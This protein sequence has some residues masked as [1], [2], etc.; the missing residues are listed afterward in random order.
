[1]SRF[2]CNSREGVRAYSVHARQVENE[3]GSRGRTKYPS[4]APG[5]T[6]SGRGVDHRSD[7][8]EYRGTFCR[9]RLVHGLWRT[10]GS[11]RGRPVRLRHTTYVPRHALPRTSGAV[12]TASF[13]INTCGAC[14]VVD[15]GRG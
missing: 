11:L 10:F 14:G 2:K 15:M 9:A 3:R 12:R 5:V 6:T 7:G 1:A 4:R 8:A 13:L